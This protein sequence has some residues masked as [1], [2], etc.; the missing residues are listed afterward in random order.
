[1]LP[2]GNFIDPYKPARYNPPASAGRLMNATRVVALQASAT[3]AIALVLL[4]RD[5]G[6]AAM[7]A[8]IGGGIGFVPALVYVRSMAVAPGADA[9]RAL[10]AQFRAEFF[11]FAATAVLFVL[12]FVWFRDVAP[13]ALFLTY[14][15]TLAM[16]WVALAVF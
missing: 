8:L 13:V 11:K 16:Y 10:S 9:R 2:C 5:G 1:M 6:N 15:A 7:S 4:V 14:L 3:V 12:T